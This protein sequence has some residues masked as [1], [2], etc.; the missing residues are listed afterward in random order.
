MWINFSL[1]G[2]EGKSN[3]SLILFSVLVTYSLHAYSV[4]DAGIIRL[5]AQS[6]IIPPQPSSSSLPLLLSRNTPFAYEPQLVSSQEGGDV[7]IVW[8]GSSTGYGE[9]DIYF[10]KSH[11]GG[12]TFSPPVIL[13]TFIGT[14]SGNT[15][16]PG[17]QQE[18]R[19]AIS[20]D[21]VYVMWSDYSAG[22]AQLAF[23][24]SSDN[25]TTFAKPITLGTVFA[26]AGETILAASDN[27]VYAVWIG[28]ADD[29]NAGSLLIKRS[30]DY[31]ETFGA[32][33]SISGM[34][35]ASMPELATGDHD[36]IF[37][38]WF[39][40]TIRDDGT[41][42]NNDIL[43]SKSIGEG[44]SFSDPINI[45]WSPDE[46]SVRPQIF[47][48]NSDEHNIVNNSFIAPLTSGII[49]DTILNNAT[50]KTL[51]ENI[52]E[53]KNNSNDIVYL[54]WLESGH[55]GRVDIAN[56]FFSRSTNGGENFTSPI[57]LSN[58]T[59][60]V[61]QI[62]VYP[63]IAA[64]EDGKVLI[65]W[66]YPDEPSPGNS[67]VDVALRLQDTA[68]PRFNEVVDSYKDVGTHNSGYYDTLEMTQELVH[69]DLAGRANNE[70]FMAASSDGGQT[71][72]RPSIISNNRGSSID[73]SVL[74]L[75]Y[76]N[77]S[78]GPDAILMWLDNS[79]GPADHFDIFLAEGPEH[80][81]GGGNGNNNVSDI[82]D[83][84]VYVLKTQG[85]SISSQ[86]GLVSQGVNDTSV[87]RD[88]NGY[89]LIVTWSEYTPSH[90]GVFVSRIAL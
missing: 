7:F 88:R 2:Q 54:A 62:E 65:S 38:T 73:P 67:A 26:A 30:Y 69:Q 35:V 1:K 20:G 84:K 75:P 34:G 66:S 6:D 77:E 43:F 40:T 63:V 76:S 15:P 33:E 82:S 5:M 31:G 3:I 28:S 19:L 36:E 39:N 55:G 52:G 47:V 14:G 13:S 16:A 68:D 64:S 37:V 78:S 17:L 12:K 49:N 9:A 57:A 71:F 59:L 18:P 58:N 41:V 51:N 8:S 53:D 24:K 80:V 4:L 90:G 45:S 74:L 23:V 32:T 79:T 44:H 85:S 83:N 56:I 42:V 81:D 89:A 60:E 86:M 70:V 11:D 25:G 50:A 46:F 48:I 87:T 61:S 10:S 27:G 29:V 21:S 72:S 22:P